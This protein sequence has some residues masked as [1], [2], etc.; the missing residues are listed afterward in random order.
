MAGQE[1]TPDQLY[2][3][4]TEIFHQQ[5]LLAEARD[6]KNQEAI[7]AIERVMSEHIEAAAK[8]LRTAFDAAQRALDK[9]ETS[10]EK[11]ND[12]AAT[13]RAQLA[14]RVSQFPDRELID[15]RFNEVN[16]R[17]DSRTE[18]LS[19]RFYADREGSG[20]EVQLVKLGLGERITREE[21]DAFVD[22]QEDIRTAAKRQ[23]GQMWVAIGVAVFSTVAG[24][25]IAVLSSGHG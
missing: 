20:R 5:E 15:N 23:L 8:E 12:E 3:H 22:R 14:D 16:A 19:R 6:A 17:L 4:F 1:W 9:A 24:I 13:F 7:T 18:E 11:R 2:I 25:V 21:F 10:Q